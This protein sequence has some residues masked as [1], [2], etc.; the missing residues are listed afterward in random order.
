MPAA[1]EL[2]AHGRSEAEV[3]ELLGCDWLIYQDL[4]DLEDAVSGPKHVLTTFDSSCFDGKYVT[5]I[6]PGYFERLQQTR[7]DDA[8]R[9]RRAG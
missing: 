6:E 4:S 9:K 8:K 5:G 7:S 1:D 2:V 3:Q